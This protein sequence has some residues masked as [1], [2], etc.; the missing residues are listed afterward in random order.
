[1]MSPRLTLDTTG[2]KSPLDVGAIAAAEPPSRPA[3]ATISTSP[4]ERPLASARPRRRGG[5]RSRLVETDPGDRPSASTPFYGT[6]RPE[7]TS[8]AISPDLAQQLVDLKH[9]TGASVVSLA[10]AAIHAGLPVDSKQA[11]REIADERLRRLDAGERIEHN[12]RLPSQ[13]RARVDELARHAHEQNPRSTRA[14]LINAALRAALPQKPDAAADLVREHAR[15]IE[16]AHA[17][18]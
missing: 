10:V 14:D 11:A 9:A 18:D 15:Q 4:A 16:R 3:P 2:I 13:L 5:A 7:Q 6:G 12:F 17:P 8:V 1:M